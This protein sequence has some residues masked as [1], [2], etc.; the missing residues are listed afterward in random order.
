MELQ[1]ATWPIIFGWGRM[2]ERF[3]NHLTSALW[4]T[5]MVGQLEVQQDWGT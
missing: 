3:G 2:I 1:Q 4:L 5:L